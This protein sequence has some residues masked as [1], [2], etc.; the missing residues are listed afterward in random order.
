MSDSAAPVFGPAKL[1]LVL[2]SDLLI[3]PLPK[4]LSLYVVMFK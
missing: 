3:T 4:L 2:P 1:I